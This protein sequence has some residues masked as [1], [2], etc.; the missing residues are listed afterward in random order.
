MKSPKKLI[1]TSKRKDQKKKK[2]MPNKVIRYIKKK[3][4]QRQFLTI[5]FLAEESLW[6]DFWAKPKNNTASSLHAH[7]Q[8][9]AG[10]SDSTEQINH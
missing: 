5:P 8:I 10:R 3:N 4:Q 9:F 6:F 2:N 1:L 7:T